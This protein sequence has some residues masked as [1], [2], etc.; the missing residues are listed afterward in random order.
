[1]FREIMMASYMGSMSNTV[2]ITCDM[3]KEGRSE[4]DIGEGWVE[5]ERP[6][7][8]KFY[9]NSSSG[10]RTWSRPDEAMPEADFQKCGGFVQKMKYDG[11]YPKGIETVAQDGY[12]CESFL[13]RL[14]DANE[15]KWGKKQA[16]DEAVAATPAPVAT[17]SAPILNQEDT[18]RP[19][20]AAQ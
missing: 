5:H 15:K 10:K 14:Y 8:K 13:E 2:G 7:G 6:D 3:G 9:V 12:D 4:M 11:K 18:W 20:T 16:M 17:P 1:M 19:T